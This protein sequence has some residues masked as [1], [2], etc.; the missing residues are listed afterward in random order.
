MFVINIKVRE[1][2]ISARRNFNAIQ[3]YF[4][5]RTVHTQRMPNFAFKE[6][7]KLPYFERRHFTKKIQPEL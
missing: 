7:E 4:E 3:K 5:I 6:K 2:L 1:T